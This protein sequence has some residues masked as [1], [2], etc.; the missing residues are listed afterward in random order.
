MAK[1]ILDGITAALAVVG[2]GILLRVGW[3][4]TGH[5]LY[6]IGVRDIANSTTINNHG[7]VVINGEERAA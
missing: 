4:L 7:H 3:S 6:R 2:V 1:E 5:F